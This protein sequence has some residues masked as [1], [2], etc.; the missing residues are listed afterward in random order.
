MA[1]R[2]LYTFGIIV[3]VI[4]HTRRPEIEKDNG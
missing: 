2:E 4:Q 1:K 3:D